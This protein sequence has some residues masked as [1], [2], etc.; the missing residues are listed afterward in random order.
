[1]LV[2][3]ATATALAT[4]GGLAAALVVLRTRLGGMPPLATVG[5]VGLALLGGVIAARLV[6]G[7]G[8]MVG[9]VAMAL[10]A[11]TYVAVLLITR[12][13]GP[14]DRAKFAKVLRR[15]S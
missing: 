5:R 8:K 4:A 15:R 1:M 13:F 3:A 12:E 11:V 2:A 7:Q 6:P 9:F 14:E 10:T